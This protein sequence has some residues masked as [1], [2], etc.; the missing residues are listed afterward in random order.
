MLE[1]AIIRMVRAEW[2]WVGDLDE[3][4]VVSD[5][6]QRNVPALLRQ[7]Q[8]CTGEKEII[9]KPETSS[10]FC[11]H[12]LPQVMNSTTNQRLFEVSYRYK[13]ILQPRRT[14]T[15]SVHY[16]LPYDSNQYVSSTIPPRE[17]WLAHYNKRGSS[18]GKMNWTWLLE[19][20]HNHTQDLRDAER[21]NSSRTAVNNKLLQ[22]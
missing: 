2:L 4:V 18:S 12:I 13:A 22:K 3:F 6:Y 16:A 7:A 15:L 1:N 9:C 10:I 8:H 17:A 19:T 14:A 21:G 5:Q 11:F 20:V